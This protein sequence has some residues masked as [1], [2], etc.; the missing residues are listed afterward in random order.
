[1]P[2]FKVGDAVVHV[3]EPTVRGRI[4]EIR[5]AEDPAEYQVRWSNRSAPAQLAENA[6]LPAEG[7]EDLDERELEDEAGS[8]E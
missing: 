3:D 8:L 2:R 5:R 1:M 6:L 7:P 4:V